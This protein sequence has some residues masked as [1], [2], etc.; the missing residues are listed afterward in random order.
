MAVEEIAEGLFRFLGRIL[1]EVLVEM[2]FYGIGL[3]FLRA[4]TFGKYPA[5]PLSN[6]ATLVCQVTGLAVVVASIGL[7]AT[8]L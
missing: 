3:V 8:L 4:V 2:V 7:I 1:F 6:R 5:D